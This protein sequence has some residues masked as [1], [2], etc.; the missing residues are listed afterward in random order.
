MPEYSSE[1]WLYEDPVTIYQTDLY[2]GADDD[3]ST[4]KFT[5]A[6]DLTEYTAA[7]FDFKFLAVGADATD[8]FNI[9]LYKRATG[10]F[11]GN[12]AYWKPLLTIANDGT[13][14]EFSYTIPREYGAGLYR[15]GIKRSGSTTVFD[16][17]VKSC[18]FRLWNVVR[19]G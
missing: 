4:E 7:N 2:S 5:D 17:Q 15:W 11:T 10:S 16:V 3:V 8:D 1:E 13:V 18:R 12:E 9:T 14:T 19:P 6:V